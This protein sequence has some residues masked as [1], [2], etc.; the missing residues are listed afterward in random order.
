MVCARGS[1]SNV[2]YL[3]PSLETICVVK[4]EEFRIAGPVAFVIGL[5]FVGSWRLPGGWWEVE[6]WV[7]ARVW[8]WLVIW[9]IWACQEASWCPGSGYRLA[10]RPWECDRPW[11]W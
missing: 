10:D 5:I 9:G 6:G 2:V 11:E 4:A 8:S 1:E 7:M 3:H